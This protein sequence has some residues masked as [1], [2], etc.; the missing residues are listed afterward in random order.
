MAGS[1]IVKVAYSCMIGLASKQQLPLPQVGLR[2]DSELARL[3]CKWRKTVGADRLMPTTVP[4]P[5][6][7]VATF[8]IG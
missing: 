5:P 4:I 3:L 1:T 7:R 6:I 8:G 2:R